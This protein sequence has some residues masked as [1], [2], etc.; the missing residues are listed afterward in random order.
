M[1]LL[2]LFMW[3]ITCRESVTVDRCYL[4]DHLINRCSVIYNTE[5]IQRKRFPPACKVR[6]SCLRTNRQP[7]HDVKSPCSYFISEIK[8]GIWGDLVCDAREDHHKA[9]SKMGLWK[10]PIETCGAKSVNIRNWLICQYEMQGVQPWL[11]MAWK[12]I[13]WW[14]L[15]TVACSQQA[16]WFTSNL[17]VIKK[18]QDTD[19]NTYS[20][21]Y[22]FQVFCPISVH[23]PVLHHKFH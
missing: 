8:R 19:V 4:I 7:S 1:L 11:F 14:K 5:D 17:H 9:V 23:P 22:L 12:F 10:N 13:F 20:I 18:C 3:F 21:I 6:I 2:Q 15:F 16:A